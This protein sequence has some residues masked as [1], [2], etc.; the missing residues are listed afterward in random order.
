MAP[1]LEEIWAVWGRPA[2]RRYHLPAGW[3]NNGPDHAGIAWSAVTK[4]APLARAVA[5]MKRS[6]GSAWK[7]SSVVSATALTPS[8]G[9]SSKPAFYQSSL[10]LWGD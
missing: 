8:R 1:E 6:A 9:I 2:R 5:T 4:V 7:V 10:Q 3:L